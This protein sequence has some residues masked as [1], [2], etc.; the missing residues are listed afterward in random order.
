MLL[1]FRLVLELVAALQRHGDEDEH[2]L[3]DPLDLG[4]HIQQVRRLKIKPKV[5]TPKKVPVTVALPPVK[6][7]PPMTTAAIASSSTSCR[8]PAR[9]W[10]VA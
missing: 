9:R 10:P 8:R 3:D 5:M 4:G 6:A 2:T 1:S 7:V